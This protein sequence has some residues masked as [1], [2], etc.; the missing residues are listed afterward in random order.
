[1]IKNS[2]TPVIANTADV[3]GRK[4]QTSAFSYK[5]QGIFALF[6]EKQN[7]HGQLN[8]KKTPHESCGV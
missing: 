6:T 5:W 8:I 7:R 1:M 4:G 2:L 3:H